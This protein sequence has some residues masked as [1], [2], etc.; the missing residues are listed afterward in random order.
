MKN[1]TSVLLS[2]YSD[3]TSKSEI[4]HSDGSKEFKSYPEGEKIVSNGFRLLS[5][6]STGSK[7]LQCEWKVYNPK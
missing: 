3:K 2:Q 6:G 1:I 4:T 7:K 5:A